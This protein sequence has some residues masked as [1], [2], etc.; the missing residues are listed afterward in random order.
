MA[1]PN[2]D[3]L[4]PAPVSGKT[5]PDCW[6][7]AGSAGDADGRAL[8][9]S[10]GVAEG[11]AL[12]GSGPDDERSASMAWILPGVSAAYTPTRAR[13]RPLPGPGPAG[14]RAGRSHR[15][16]VAVRH[17]AIRPAWAG[18]MGPDHSGAL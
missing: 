17:G 13:P 8:A 5:T 1:R 7:L 3:V 11:E 2:A 12:V 9:G 18:R 15:R 6:G 16:G 14:V 4:R 10:A